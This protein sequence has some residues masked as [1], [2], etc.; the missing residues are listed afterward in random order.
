[1]R[2]IRLATVACFAASMIACS[3][4]AAVSF[5]AVDQQTTDS[6]PAWSTFEIDPL[7]PRVSAEEN[8]PMIAVRSEDDIEEHIREAGRAE[9]WAS[10]LQEDAMQ[11]KRALNSEVDLKKNEK[12]TLK[13]RIKLA[14]ESE[15]EVEKDRLERE[16]ELIEK[17]QKRLERRRDLRGKEEDLGKAMKEEAK[18]LQRL[19]EHELELRAT[20]RRYIRTEGR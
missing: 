10:D 18:S 16:L 14:K 8:L 9:S 4:T 12:E 3:T 20:P 13:A 7:L 19:L 1:M 5:S 17:D 11:F 6:K 15:E 2:K